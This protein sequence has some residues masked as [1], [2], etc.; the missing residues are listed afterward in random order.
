MHARLLDIVN[1]GGGAGDEPRVFTTAD[2]FS[3]QFPGG[4]RREYGRRAIFPPCFTLTS[5]MCVIPAEVG[6]QPVIGNTGFPLPAFARPASSGMTG[7]C[8]NLGLPVDLGRARSRTHLGRSGLHRIHN[9]LVAG[10]TAEIA[11]DAVADFLF[12]GHRVQVAVLCEL[13]NG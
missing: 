5:C 1:A 7:T 11:L 8:L 9:V 3:N 12:C 6:I 4:L 2:T 13:F 10:A